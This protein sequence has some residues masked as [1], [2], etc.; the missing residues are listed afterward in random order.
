M[1]VPS[2]RILRSLGVAGAA[3]VGFAC[4]AGPALAATSVTG[5]GST[6]A[7]P[8]YSKWAK[9]YA[10]VTKGAVKVNYAL[11]G[12]GGGINAIENGTVNFGGTDAPLTS[13]QLSSQNLTQFPTAVGGVVPIV[14]LG[15]AS[16][17]LKL[18][19]PVLAN[20]YMGSIKYWD[21]SQIKSLN[22]GLS[23]PHTPI[24]VI[25]RSDSSGTT[26][27]FTHYLS[28][29]SST[30]ASKVGAST[31]VRWPVGTGFSQ[32][33]GVAAAVRQI[34]GRIGYVEYA[35]AIQAHISYA[36]LKNRASHWVLPSLGSFKAAAAGATWSPANGFAT[37]LVNEGG[38]GAWPITGATFA[39]VRNS[40][41]NYATEHAMLKF[42]DWGYKSSAGK[43][44]AAGLDYVG[45]SSS[46]VSKV[47][48]VWHSKVK[49]GGKSVW[50]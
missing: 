43:S 33:A 35:Y 50:P 11:T 19:G 41:S 21:D 48:S 10:S 24:S 46:V 44:D 13:A 5:S 40:T 30:W 29:V 23:L 34:K 31:A 7:G 32:S 17:R 15:I 4:L 25:H 36:Q 38:S 6:F 2:K 8:L 47:E 3:A 16:G 28:A 9:N 45:M 20:I 1:R 26:W 42:F 27:I 18:S 37:V 12:S 22:P 14:N 39:L 49:A